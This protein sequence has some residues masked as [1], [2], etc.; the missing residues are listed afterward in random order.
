MMEYDEQWCNNTFTYLTHQH[1]DEQRLVQEFKPMDNGPLIPLPY[2][3]SDYPFRFQ[4]VHHFHGA[5][6]NSPLQDE[7]NGLILLNHENYSKVVGTDEYK[8]STLGVSI[9][10]YL[11]NLTVDLQDWANGHSRMTKEELEDVCIKIF[12]E[13]AE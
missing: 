12:E 3:R 8:I 2:N 10:E 9:Y 11:Q 4:I 1:D 5:N 13:W 6:D 7:L